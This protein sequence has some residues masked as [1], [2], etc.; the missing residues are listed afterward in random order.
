MEFVWAMS[1]DQWVALQQD[2][3]QK[4][5]GVI[6]GVSAGCYGVCQ[7]GALRA[8]IQHTL[9]ENDWYAFCNVYALGV[10]DGYGNTEAGKP[11]ALLD[12]A[13]RI[14]MELE[15]FCEFKIQFE[16]HFEEYINK[17]EKAKTLAAEPLGNWN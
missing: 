7:V 11:Y 5:A 10:D 15:T 9:D 8:E 16:K 4:G 2:N 17:S 6:D 12:D 1:R 13:P 3:S 14:P